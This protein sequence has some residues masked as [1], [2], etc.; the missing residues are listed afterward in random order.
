MN[1]TDNTVRTYIAIQRVFRNAV[2]KYLRERLRAAFG[3]NAEAELR[4]PF[5]AEEWEKVRVGAEEPR[6]LQAV[7]NDIIDDF[8]LLSVNHFFNIFDKHWNVLKPDDKELNAG[9]DVVKRGLL[10]FLREVKAVRDPISHPPEADLT[11]EDA[12]RVIDSARRALATLRLPEAT[13]LTAS[14]NEIW[15][16]AVEPPTPL[17]AKLPPNDAIVQRFV[18][19]DAELL[20]LWSWLTDPDARRWLLVGAD[21][22]NELLSRAISSRYPLSGLCS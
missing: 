13:E 16:A 22:G 19:R 7:T 8:D 11:R 12:F 21:P 9:S 4:K 3:S 20:D 14:L 6:A 1:S 2:V 10:G 18:G 15:S 5:K 17:A